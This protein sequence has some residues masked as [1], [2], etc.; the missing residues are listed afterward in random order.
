MDMYMENFFSDGGITDLFEIVGGD[1]R[2][3]MSFG[4]MRGFFLQNYRQ[5]WCL[6]SQFF[7]SLLKALENV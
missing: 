3:W 4:K 5:V 6:W 1:G 2:C 7:L